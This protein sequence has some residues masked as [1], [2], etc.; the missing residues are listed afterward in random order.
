MIVYSEV[1][2]VLSRTVCLSPAGTV[3]SALCRITCN[4][5]SEDNNVYV[6]VMFT[7]VDHY[8]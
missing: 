5:R 4:Q 8:F 7:S 3:P 2:I 6:L 1:E